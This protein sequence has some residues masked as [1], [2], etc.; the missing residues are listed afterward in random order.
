MIRS[1]WDRTNSSNNTGQ[2][3][4]NNSSSYNNSSINRNTFIQ[5]AQTVIPQ[6]VN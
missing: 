5:P 1:R 3:G 2:F 6:V 4:I